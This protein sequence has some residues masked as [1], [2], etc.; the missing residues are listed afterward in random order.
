MT[1]AEN[2]R[3][4]KRCTDKFEK[5]MDEYTKQF[6]VLTGQR[7][8]NKLSR[9]ELYSR[10]NSTKGLTPEEAQL[11]ENK[12]QHGDSLNEELDC[13]RRPLDNILDAFDV[14]EAQLKEKRH[15]MKHSI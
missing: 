13:L 1:H 11:L 15:S 7:Y 6:E 12:E 5:L 4:K 8:A 2:E 14:L 3:S 10:R 9:E